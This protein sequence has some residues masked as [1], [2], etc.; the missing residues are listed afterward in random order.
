[1]RPPTIST[2]P[3]ASLVAVCWKR[4]V[5]S[6][7]PA[8]KRPVAGSKY[9]TAPTKAPLG[10]TMRTPPMM[11]TRPSVSRVAVAEARS[12]ASEATVR[13]VSLAGVYRAAQPTVAGAPFTSAMPPT[14][15]TSPV[16]RSTAV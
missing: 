12:V 7:G 13:Q 8:V 14:T 3:S 16:V 6:V 5:A 4:G 11:A 15:S 10:A 9:S 2:R 1:M